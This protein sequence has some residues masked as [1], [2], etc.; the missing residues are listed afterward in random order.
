MRDPG[1]SAPLA[2][3]EGHQLLL[4]VLTVT[5][6]CQWF[7]CPLPNSALTSGS[8]LVTPDIL[9]KP[10]SPILHTPSGDPHYLL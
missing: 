6:E 1:R 4:G 7:S 2:H 10:F 3:T 8:L 9:P 5:D